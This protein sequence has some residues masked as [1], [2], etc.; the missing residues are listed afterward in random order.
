MRSNRPG[1]P[2]NNKINTHKDKSF[3]KIFLDDVTLETE[4]NTPAPLEL[5]RN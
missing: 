1:S 3:Q 2:R 4:Q 5:S